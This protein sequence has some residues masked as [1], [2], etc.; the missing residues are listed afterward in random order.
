MSPS[1]SSPTP[2]AASVPGLCDVFLSHN[3]ADKP[4]VE[5]LARR[6]LAARIQPWLDSWD[7]IP[8]DPWQE[9]VEEALDTCATCAVFLGPSGVGPWHNEELRVAL[10]RRARDRTRTFRVIPV[11]LPGADLADPNTLPRFLSRMTW[12][13]F[14]NGLDN[15]NA[16]NRLLAG[17]RGVAPG[18]GLDVP[19]APS[20]PAGSSSTASS[21]GVL[22]ANQRKRLED[23]LARLQTQFDTYTR[24]LAALD[25]DIG[26]ALGSLE[27]QVLQERRVEVEAE[28]KQV[29]EQ[30]QR[31][32]EQLR[33]P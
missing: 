31:I 24:R 25:T 7:L 5:L 14:R 12:V 26:R 30:M 20:Q 33:Q 8:G 17:I 27:K 29:T 9:G 23:E 22:T 2:T 3:S 32:E 1:T 19:S 18:P 6:L 10:D 16:F 15:A 11:L 28:R 4:A 13:D 21:A